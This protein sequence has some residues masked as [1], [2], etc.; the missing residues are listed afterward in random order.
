MKKTS[1]FIK[2]PKH[3]GKLQ[4]KKSDKVMRNYLESLNIE[5]VK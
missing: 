4:T 2:L 1:L 3:I 5:E